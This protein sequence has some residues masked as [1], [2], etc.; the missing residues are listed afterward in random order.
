MIITLSGYPGSGKSTAGKLLAAKLGYNRYSIGDL[1]RRLA[2]EHNLT[3][4]ATGACHVEADA[5]DEVA[6][7]QHQLQ[8]LAAHVDELQ[9]QPRAARFGLG[10]Q[11]GFYRCDRVLCDVEQ[12][13]VQLRSQRA[14]RIIRPREA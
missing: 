8:R 10:D 3:R 5:S 11:P 4:F 12:N 7:H 13:A 1:Q 2:A 6:L 9:R 14:D